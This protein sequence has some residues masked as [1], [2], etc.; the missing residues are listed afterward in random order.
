MTLRRLELV[1]GSHSYIGH[2]DRREKSIFIC[3]HTTPF[4]TYNKFR[5]FSCSLLIMKR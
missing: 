5:N 3:N 1:S 4:S 2:F